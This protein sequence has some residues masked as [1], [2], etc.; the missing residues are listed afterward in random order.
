MVVDALTSLS[1]DHETTKGRNSEK[2]I[3]WETSNFIDSELDPIRFRRFVVSCFRDEFLD[4]TRHDPAAMLGR[5]IFGQ[6]RGERVRR[7]NGESTMIF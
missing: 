1:G 4:F 7:L 6:K 2:Q 5:L 3:F